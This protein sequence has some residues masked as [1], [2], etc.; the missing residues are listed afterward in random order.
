MDSMWPEE[1]WLKPVGEI[2]VS[3]PK[4]IRASRLYQDHTPGGRN[5][6]EMLVNKLDDPL[7][8]SVAGK[9]F[10]AGPVKN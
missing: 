3:L 6:T 5:V 7:T 4:N 8:Q 10:V 1:D 9:S 2:K